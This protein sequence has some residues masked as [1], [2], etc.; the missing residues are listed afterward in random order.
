MSVTRCIFLIRLLFQQRVFYLLET[1]SLGYIFLDI[2]ADQIFLFHFI[3]C[4]IKQ[5]PLWKVEEVTRFCV[6]QTAAVLS[7]DWPPVVRTAS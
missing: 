5:I 4:L 2:S 1:S 3:S 7:L 6:L